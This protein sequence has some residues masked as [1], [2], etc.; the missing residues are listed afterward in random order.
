[1]RR[2][3]QVLVFDADDTLWENNVLFE[4]VIE[5]FLAWLEHP[6]LDKRQL[7]VILDDIQSANAVTH[8]YGT[9]MLLRSLADCVERLRSRPA[10]AQELDEIRELAAALIDYQVELIPGVAD[11][12]AALSDRHE[13]LLLTKGDQA[14]QQRKIDASQL[15]HQFKAV[16]IVPEKNDETYHRFINAHALD[17]ATSWMIGNSPKSDILPARAAGM[18]AV[19]IP[20]DHTWVL[21]HSEL[22]PDDD[23]VLRLRTFRELLDHF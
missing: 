14:E 19:F 15:A 6:T 23:R 10:T 21:E 16:G 17:P 4:R 13:L 1:M 5:D 12:L 18:N 8:G 22:D 3:G 11:T 2:N 20:N 7:R 9:Q